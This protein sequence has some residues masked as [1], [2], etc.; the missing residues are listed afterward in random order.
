VI[1]RITITGLV[2]AST[3]VTAI[4]AQSLPEGKGRAELQRICGKCHGVDHATKPRLSADAWSAVVDDMATRGAQG[5]DD[6]LDLIVKYLV[7]N[8][9]TVDLNTAGAREIAESLGLSQKDADAIVEYRSSKGAFK[10]WPDLR[11]VPK[12]DFEKLES[13]KDRIV[14]TATSS[15]AEDRK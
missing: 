7:A 9:S 1:L 6:E 4:V 8:F 2:F 12:I 13:Q 5:S 15:A 14:F 3:F 11:R 10:D